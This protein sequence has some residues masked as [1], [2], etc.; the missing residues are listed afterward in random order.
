MLLA[1]KV[2]PGT[3]L[4][5]RAENGKIEFDTIRRPVESELISGS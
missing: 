2:P 5:A 3:V 1:E 4:L